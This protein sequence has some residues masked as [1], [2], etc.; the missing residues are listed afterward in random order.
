MAFAPLLNRCGGND[1]AN[2]ICPIDDGGNVVKRCKD[3]LGAAFRT[4]LTAF[5]S[6]QTGYCLDVHEYMQSDNGNQFTPRRKGERIKIVRG[7]K[8]K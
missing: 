3:N 2:I 1:I 5:N 4:L 7:K 8:A 6:A